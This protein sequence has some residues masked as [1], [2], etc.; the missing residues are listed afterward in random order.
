MKK[1]LKLKNNLATVEIHQDEN[2]CYY[3]IRKNDRNKIINKIDHIQYFDLNNHCSLIKIDDNILSKV[4]EKFQNTNDYASCFVFF[5]SEN[6][7]PD[8][9]TK[10]EKSRYEHSFT[11]TGIKFWR[12]QEQMLNYKNGNPN[13]VVSTHISPEGAC[14]L[15]CPYC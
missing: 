2:N 4:K 3:L 8:D 6:V 11:S 15:K 9:Y 12:H 14:N 5:E 1:I 13:S 10:R 7:I